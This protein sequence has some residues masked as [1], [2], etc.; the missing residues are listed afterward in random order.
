MNFHVHS[1]ARTLGVIAAVLGALAAV[2]GTP[3]RFERATSLSA[4]DV[5]HVAGRERERVSAR[6]LAEW[7]RAGTPS[8]RVL[9]LRGDSAFAKHHIPSAEAVPLSML[10][11]VARAG[12]TL[13]LYSDDDVRDA[14]AHAWLQASGHRGT[15]VLRGGM[16]AWMADVIDPVVA[17]DS[18][19]HV[20]ALSRYFG[21]VP[22]AAT[23]KPADEPVASARATRRSNARA[24]LTPAVAA[25]DEFENV[26]RRGC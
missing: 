4:T 10:D 11:S 24:S 2:V 17:G 12:E 7:I 19:E 26:G 8:L 21:G 16:S 22:R 5:V 23:D 9:D 25:P 1:G 15:Y 18:A 3:A 6:E 14:L 20:A 13:V